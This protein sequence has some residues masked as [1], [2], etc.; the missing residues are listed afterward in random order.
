MRI[1]L[2][3]DWELRVTGICTEEILE[4]S[5]PRK[6]C[7]CWHGLLLPYQLSEAAQ[8]SYR[9]EHHFSQ[10]TGWETEDREKGVDFLKKV[11]WKAG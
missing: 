1:L 8:Q 4:E 3:I 10:I 2:G 6:P 5:L 9:E 11:K 7:Y